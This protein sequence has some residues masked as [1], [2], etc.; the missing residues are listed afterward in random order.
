[1]GARRTWS[2]GARRGHPHQ[3]PGFPFY[4]AQNYFGQAQ[5]Q[6]PQWVGGQG[7]YDNMNNYMNR[8]VVAEQQAKIAI[9]NCESLKGAQ[10]RADRWAKDIKIKQEQDKYKSPADKRPVG[11]LM[12]EYFDLKEL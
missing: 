3:I 2:T 5:G 10:V 11:Y 12:E 6:A 4:P 8:A 1:M 7:F 9:Q